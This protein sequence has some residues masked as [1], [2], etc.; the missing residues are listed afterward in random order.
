MKLGV[1]FREVALTFAPGLLS[2]MRQGFESVLPYES[3]EERQLL[4]KQYSILLPNMSR[5]KRAIDQYAD[6][7]TDAGRN[8]NHLSPWL[9]TLMIPSNMQ[10]PFEVWPGFGN[11]GVGQTQCGVADI[12]EVS[13]RANGDGVESERRIWT[14]K[15][16]IS[17]L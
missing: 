2:A 8:A 15:S 12:H 5:R 11:F 9:D 7:S 13:T 4:M 6:R 16:P 17:V 10:W 14:E 1:V 3:S